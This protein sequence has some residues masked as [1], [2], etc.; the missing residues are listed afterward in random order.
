MKNGLGGFLPPRLQFL[1]WRARRN[2][3]LR[4]S[5][6]L[7]GEAVIDVAV[8]GFICPHYQDHV[9]QRRVVRKAPIPLCNLRRRHVLRTPLVYLSKVMGVADDGLFL[10]IADNAV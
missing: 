3:A 9:P 8:V 1:V 6:E 2:G 4:K 10:E 5:G 7:I